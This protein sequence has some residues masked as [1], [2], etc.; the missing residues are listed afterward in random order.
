MPKAEQYITALGLTANQ[1]LQIMNSMA[2]KLRQIQT[3]EIAMLMVAR[4]SLQEQEL[5]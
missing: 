1:L 3:L 4:S 2:I 5:I